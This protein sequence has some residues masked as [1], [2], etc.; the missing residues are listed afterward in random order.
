LLLYYYKD[1]QHQDPVV[2]VSAMKN[3]F[4]ELATSDSIKRQIALPNTGDHV[5]ASPIKSNDITSVEKE[6]KRFLEEVIHLP[7][8]L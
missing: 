8:K 2:K 6:T 4:K 7:L 3:M 5:I 1:E